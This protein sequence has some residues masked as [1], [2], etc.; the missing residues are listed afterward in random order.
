MNGEVHPDDPPSELADALAVA[1]PVW[2]ERCVTATAARIDGTVSPQLRADAVD[3][4]AAV[5]PVVTDRLRQLLS[6][7][8][9]EQRA[10][11][12]QVLRSSV[13]APTDVLRRHGVA[14][15]ERDEF[16]RRSFPDDVYGLAPASWG[17]VDPA[18]VEPGVGW[19]A[20]K[21]ATVR[22]RR[23]EEGRR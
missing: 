11:P 5:A 21:A 2:L 10:N 9:D 13:A 23:R 14:T 22:H 16:A 17:D 6:T 15:V 3:M 19:G 12:L 20:W 18:L 8:V 1:V 4:A 7:D